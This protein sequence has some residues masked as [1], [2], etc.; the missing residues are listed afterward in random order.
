MEN[1]LDGTV[2]PVTEF[3]PE[4]KLIHIDSERRAIGEIDA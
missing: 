3:F 2:S 1:S 4:L